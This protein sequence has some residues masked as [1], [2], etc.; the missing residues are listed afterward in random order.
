MSDMNNTIT[1]RLQGDQNQNF[2]TTLRELETLNSY[3]RISS[4]Y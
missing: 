2:I 4:K 1:T 3:S